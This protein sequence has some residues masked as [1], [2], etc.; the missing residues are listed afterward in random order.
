M[1]ETKKDA[2]AFDTFVENTR[3]H[4]KRVRD[5][6]SPTGG[7]MPQGRQPYSMC[8]PSIGNIYAQQ[9]LRLP[10]LILE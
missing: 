2:L 10:K 9:I 1:A 4:R 7:R 6:S 5:G 3:Y 8:G